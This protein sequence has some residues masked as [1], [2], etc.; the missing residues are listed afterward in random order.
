MACIIHKLSSSY[1][2]VRIF[3]RII[4]KLSSLC[5]L[6]R[7]ITSIFRIYLLFII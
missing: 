1:Y 4:Q 2:L 6:V 5:Y 3:T 7:V